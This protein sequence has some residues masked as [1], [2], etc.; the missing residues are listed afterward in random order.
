M[1]LKTIATYAWA[2]VL[3]SSFSAIAYADEPAIVNKV[4]G[5]D[6]SWQHG[7]SSSAP[8]VQTLLNTGDRVSAGKGSFVEVEYLADNCKVRVAA[9]SSVVIADTS[10]CSAKSAKADVPV[11]VKVVPVSTGAVEVSDKKGPVTRVK[12]GD[13]MANISVGENLNVGDM[14]FAGANSSVT[15][16][17]TLPQCS[18]TVSAGTVYKIVEKPPCKAAA[19]AGGSG[20]AAVGTVAGVAPTGLALGAGAVVVGGAAI[21]V[22]A[23]SQGSSNNDKPAS[24]D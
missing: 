13:G 21:A 20:A 7:D 9:G 15:L 19:A 4:V 17:F 5:K 6:V 11:D 10:P 8:K 24:P 12:T 3:A 2:S 14:V 23:T 22:I 16:F 18:Y 1:H